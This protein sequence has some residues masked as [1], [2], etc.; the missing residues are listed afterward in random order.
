[1]LTSPTMMLLYFL[2]STGNRQEVSCTAALKYTY[3][4]KKR[5]ADFNQILYYC[6]TSFESV[7]CG[8]LS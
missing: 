4:D 6:F 7:S 1:M 2:G 3:L 5:Y 8:E